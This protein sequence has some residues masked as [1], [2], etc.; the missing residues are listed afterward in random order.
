MKCFFIT[1]HEKE[2]Q[3]KRMWRVLSVKHSGYYAWRKRTLSAQ[4]KANEAL[5]TMIEMQYKR[6]RET[7]GSPRLH[8]VL[9]R[10]GITCGRNRVVQRM[11]LHRIV[12]HTKGNYHP[13][14][15]QP[16]PGVILAPN[17]LDRDI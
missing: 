4:S 9:Q 10:E 11:R 6:S 17:L 3:I 7:Y 2:F 5:L 13:E 15:T 1:A 12:A 14:T 8:V 16:Q